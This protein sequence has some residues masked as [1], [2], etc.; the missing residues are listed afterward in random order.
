M[1]RPEHGER[2]KYDLDGFRTWIRM[3][4][5]ELRE[6]AEVFAWK[7]NKSAGRVKV[8]IPLRGWSAVD[9]PGSPTYD[10]MEDAIFVRGLRNRLKKDIE[11][12]E[13]DANMEDPEFAR[14]VISAAR[15]VF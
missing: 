13:V 12:I 7:L 14:A 11:I 15:C 2:R 6:V 9:S 1:T 5:K 4:P 8:V 10:P 3:T